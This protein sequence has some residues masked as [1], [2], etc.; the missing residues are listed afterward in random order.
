MTRESAC[1]IL[2]VPPHCTQ[3]DAKRAYHNLAR[4]FHPDKGGDAGRFQDVQRAHEHL[5]AG[6]RRDT[7]ARSK[8]SESARRGVAKKS[9]AWT[10]RS[11]KDTRDAT[12]DPDVASTSG[13]AKHDDAPSSAVM[14]G[15]NLRALG[16]EALKAR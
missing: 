4:A 16:D 2:G 15:E 10:A 1:A 6:W 9:S 3:G 11:G 12:R 7:E 13:D 8:V 5:V 14:P